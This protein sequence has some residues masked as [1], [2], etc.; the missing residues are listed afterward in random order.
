MLFVDFCATYHS[1][2][3]LNVDDELLLQLMLLLKS[4]VA[5]SVPLPTVGHERHSVRRL[6]V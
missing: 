2:L 3:M 4:T 1:L 5:V 6:S